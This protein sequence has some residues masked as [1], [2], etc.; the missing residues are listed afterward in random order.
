[1]SALLELFHNLTNPDWIMAHGG[2]Y[3]VVFIVFAE[4]GLFAG[5]FL[6]GDSLL[7]ITGMIIAQSVAPGTEPVL[8]LLYWVLLISGAAIIGNYVGYWFGKRSG[9]MLMK[10]KDSWLFKRNT[11]SRHRLFMKRRVGAP[12]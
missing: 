6:P 2:L 11:W 12:L 9:E 7:F 10:R 5:F 4:T 1:M 3:F 8:N